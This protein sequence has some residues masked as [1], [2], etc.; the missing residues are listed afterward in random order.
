[1]DDN[2]IKVFVD[3][4]ILNA[5]AITG[6]G[7]P[8]TEFFADILTEQVK[9]FLVEYGYEALTCEEVRFALF[10]NEKRNVRLMSGVELVYVDFTGNHFNVSYLSKILHNYSILRTYL[11]R[12]FQNFIDGHE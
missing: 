6:C 7:L 9:V 3:K 11:D 1:M 2:E 8:Q 10:I 5:A 12:K 4:L